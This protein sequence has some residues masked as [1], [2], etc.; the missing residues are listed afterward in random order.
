M[1]DSCYRIITRHIHFG[2]TN[3]NEAP[4]IFSPIL[5][6]NL[7]T[8]QPESTQNIQIHNNNMKKVTIIEFTNNKIDDPEEAIEKLRKTL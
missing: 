8:S 3:H 2:D 7:E 4:V 5:S 1:C 6:P